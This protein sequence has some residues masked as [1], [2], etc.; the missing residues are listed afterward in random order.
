MHTKLL[1]T[2]VYTFILQLHEMSITH[3][4]CNLMQYRGLDPSDDIVVW[5][6][7]LVDNLKEEEKALLLKFATGTPRAPAGGF[8]CLQ[9]DYSYY[10]L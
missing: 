2:H 3:V 9:V 7:K 4:A 10:K 8:S 1:S 5:F 6:W